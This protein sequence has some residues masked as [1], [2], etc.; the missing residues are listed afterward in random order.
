[1]LQA[2]MNRCECSLN[3]G[4]DV[5]FHVSSIK[6]D[7]SPPILAGGY[8]GDPLAGAENLKGGRPRGQKCRIRLADFDG[9]AFNPMGDQVAQDGGKMVGQAGLNHG[10]TVG[11]QKAGDNA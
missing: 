9:H 3:M 4:R 8:K 6:G 11:C 1:V 7:M 2:S 5:D 10:R